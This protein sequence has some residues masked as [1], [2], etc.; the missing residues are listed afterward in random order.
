MRPS[1]NYPI[2]AFLGDDQSQSPLLLSSA[3]SSG[4]SL[5]TYIDKRGRIG[6]VLGWTK[7]NALP[8]VT[9]DDASSA[10]IPGMFMYRKVAAGSITRQVLF[11][12]D[13]GVD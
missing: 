11:T 4:G 6:S 3:Y 12:L 10:F 1:L 5:N 2:S 7:Q 8:Y 9:H 13:D